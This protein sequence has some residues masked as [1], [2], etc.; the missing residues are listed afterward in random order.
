MR[1][2]VENTSKGAVAWITNPALRAKLWENCF[3]LHA[4]RQMGGIVYEGTKMDA[5]VWVRGNLLDKVEYIGN[6]LTRTI[7][8]NAT[9]MACAAGYYDGLAKGMSGRMLWDYASDVGARTQTMYNR[10]SITGILR[11]P[12]VGAVLPFQ[13]FPA[14]M[15]TTIRETIPIRQFAAGAWRTVAAD[16]IT[17]KALIRNRVKMI[18]EFYAAMYS[19][20]LASASVT[21]RRPWDTTSFLPFYA[22]VNL[23]I[24]QYTFM[25]SWGGGT[26]L[27]LAYVQEFQRGIRDIIQNDDWDRMR[28]W[29]LRY[30]MMG[31][32]QANRMIDGIIAVLH[33]G[34]EDVTGEELY[35]VKPEEFLKAVL[36]GPASTEG[37]KEYYNRMRGAD[38]EIDRIRDDVIA[39]VDKLGKTDE[40]GY[41]YTTHDLARDLMELARREDLGESPESVICGEMAFPDLA[42]FYFH[43]RQLIDQYEK[44]PEGERSL[45]RRQNPF[46][47]AIL[48]MFR[49]GVGAPL[50]D[51]GKGYA[52]LLVEKWGISWN[53]I[54]GTSAQRR[55]WGTWIDIAR[56]HRIEME[57]MFWEEYG[58]NFPSGG[59]SE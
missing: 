31:G 41:I 14:E 58:R 59:I 56:K 42:E 43:C 29:T 19:C 13:S 26:I 49:P 28:S 45:W 2:G 17:G 35:K 4:K 27:P 23:G 50:T 11:S 6:Y 34:V 18:L 54:P 33:G 47:D 24:D 12:I 38:P 20:N 53:A 25:A 51:T 5:E 3:S 55:E 39:T 22:L 10:E 37:G 15:L 8:I 40:K 9:G 32:V 1:T 30:N 7:E 52:A 21:G 46:A 48:F 57:I 44:L 16:S 36:L